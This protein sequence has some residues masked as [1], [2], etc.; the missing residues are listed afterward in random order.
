[1]NEEHDRKWL[2]P[3]FTISGDVDAED[4]TV[5]LPDDGVG[6]E[7][8]ELIE[9]KVGRILI[10]VFKRKILFLKTHLILESCHGLVV[11]AR[12]LKT[13]KLR[14]QSLPAGGLYWMECK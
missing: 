1:M 2:L 4:Q 12:G 9:N 11:K 8:V 10:Y 7:H 5:L 13:N 6:E 3:F 14:V